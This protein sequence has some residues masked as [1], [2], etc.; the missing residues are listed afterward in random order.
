MKLLSHPQLRVTSLR[1]C[2]LSCDI[3]VMS[4]DIVNGR[5]E[6]PPVCPES[7]VLVSARSSRG[8]V[9]A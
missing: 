1:K 9:R 4:Q 3:C 2:Q 7:V 6:S 5:I 8:L